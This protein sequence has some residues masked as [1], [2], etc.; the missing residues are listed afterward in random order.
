MRSQQALDAIITSNTKTLN[1]LL[2]SV[3]TDERSLLELQVMMLARD[4]TISLS[5]QE[6][7]DYSVRV[8]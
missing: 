1:Q 8:Y 6:D 3:P 7:G 4:G 2:S 5:K